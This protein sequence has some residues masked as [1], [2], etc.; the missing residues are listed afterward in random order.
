MCGLTGIFSYA[1]NA[2]SVD[3]AELLRMRE[4]MIARG[5][6]A[7][8]LWVS[9]DQQVGLAHRRLAIIDLSD[10]GA[11]PMVS[12]DGRFHIVF[13]GEIYNYHELK[14]QLKARGA[15]FKSQSDTEVLLQLYSRHGASMCRKLRGMYAFAIWD[16]VEHSMF[17]ARDPFGI[18]PLYIANDGRTFR[19]ASQVATFGWCR[20][21]YH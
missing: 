8:G 16:T 11:Q 15:V 2:P 5:P 21:K 18:K 14:A 13:N 19:F 17:L 1:D 9:D 20:P 7:A 4:Q 12:S 3:Q 6:D 10:D